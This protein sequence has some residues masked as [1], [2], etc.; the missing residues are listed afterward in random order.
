MA[1][2]EGQAREKRGLMGELD[3]TSMRVFPGKLRPQS[4]GG[5]LRSPTSYSDVLQDGF[6]FAPER[7]L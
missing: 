4:R 1:K 6:R 2:R 3:P 7:D 5:S